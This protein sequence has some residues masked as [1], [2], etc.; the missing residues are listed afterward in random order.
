MEAY[1][2]EID[3]L[4]RNL[5]LHHTCPDR[6]KMVQAGQ[7]FL[8]NTKRMLHKFE[9]DIA[10]LRLTY[11]LTKEQS[12]FFKPTQTILYLFGDLVRYMETGDLTFLNNAYQSKHC[13]NDLFEGAHVLQSRP[14]FRVD[15]AIKTTLTD[16]EA[17][18]LLET[19]AECFNNCPVN[20]WAAYR[21]LRDLDTYIERISKLF[22]YLHYVGSNHP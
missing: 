5:A 4:P 13:V 6:M 9:I 2:A 22:R 21:V 17:K 12:P 16:E 14:S 20:D 1:Y 15:A 18:K 8:E 3:S 10:E 19:L 11:V 7:R